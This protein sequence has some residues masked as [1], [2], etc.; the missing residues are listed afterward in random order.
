MKQ[1]FVDYWLSFAQANLCLRI[2]IFIEIELVDM[3]PRWGGSTVRAQTS[4]SRHSTFPQG[5]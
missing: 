4:A 2:R 3:P 1:R 5:S